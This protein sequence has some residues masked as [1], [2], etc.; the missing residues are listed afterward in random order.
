MKSS[1]I[2]RKIDDLGRVVIPAG[3][4]KSLSIREGDAVDVWVDGDRVVLA[5]PSDR[6]VFCGTEE[7]PLHDY[8]EKRVC[9][10]CVASV[11]VLDADLRQPATVEQPEPVAHAAAASPPAAP[12]RQNEGLPAWD[13]PPRTSRPA[14][15]SAERHPVRPYTESPLAP[16]VVPEPQRS[17]EAASTAW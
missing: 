8:R 12:R 5:K 17:D 16:A 6:C 1:G 13:L 4:R 3:I 11:S 7:P 15:A 2:R 14:P 10:P 9:R